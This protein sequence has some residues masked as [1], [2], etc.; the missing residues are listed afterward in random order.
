VG[1]K[2]E[3]AERELEGKLPPFSTY[4]F[5]FKHKEDKNHKKTTQKKTKRREGTYL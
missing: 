2:S 3:G 1:A 4:F 5:L